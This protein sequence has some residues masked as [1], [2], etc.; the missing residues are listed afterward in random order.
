MKTLVCK[1]VVGNV[2][3]GNDVTHKEERADITISD[4]IQRN[5]C[6]SSRQYSQSGQDHQP[7]VNLWSRPEIEAGPRQSR[8]HNDIK[9]WHDQEIRNRQTWRL[10]DRKST[11]L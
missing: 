7:L 10:Q 1:G 8:E 4:E 9:E 11:R 3:E 2:C 5:S 6:H